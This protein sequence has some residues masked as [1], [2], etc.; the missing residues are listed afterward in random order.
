M[1]IFFEWR[2]FFHPSFILHI[3]CQVNPT[4]YKS[5]TRFCIFFCSRTLYNIAVAM[6]CDAILVSIYFTK[7]DPLLDYT[8]SS[9]SITRGSKLYHIVRISALTRFDCNIKDGIFVGKKIS[10]QIHRK[11]LNYLKLNKQINKFHKWTK[12]SLGI[13]FF[14]DF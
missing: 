7:I 14:F 6:W 11:I 9:L 5:F 2:V 3:V 10:A 4:R 13:H 1:P 8:C 12:K